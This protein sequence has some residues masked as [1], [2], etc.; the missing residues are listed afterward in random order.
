MLSLTR[1][2]GEEID[3]FENGK[4]IGSIRLVETHGD[5]ARIGFNFPKNFEINRRELSLDKYPDQA[6]LFAG[7]Q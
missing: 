1:R 3:L 4:W 2:T 6:F 5:K 7:A